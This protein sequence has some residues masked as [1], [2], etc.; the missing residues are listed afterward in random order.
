MGET[1]M[2]VFID[3]NGDGKPDLYVASGGYEFREKDPL[4]QD[5]IYLND[6]KGNFTKS[7]NSLP[8]MLFSKG[9]V[10]AADVNGDGAMDI[11]VGGR[12]IPGKYPVTPQSMLLLNDGHGHF[13]DATAKI[14]PQLD[15]LGMVTDAVWIDVNGDKKPDLIVVGEWMPIKVFVNHNGKLVDESSKYIKF[16]SY[17]LWNKIFAADLNGDGKLDLVVGNV[18]LNTQFKMS[19]QYPMSVCYKDFDKNGTIDPIL[20]YYIDGKNY[21]AVSQDDITGQVPVLKKKFLTYS[22]YADATMEDLFTPDKMKGAKTLIAQ[23]GE[24]VYLQNTGN[25]FV[26]KKLPIEAQYSPVYSITTVD[27]NHDGKP[28]L[29]L[30]GNNAWTRVKFGRYKANHGILLINDGKGNFK[31]IPQFQSGLNLRDDIR[32]AETINSASGQKI[33]FGANDAPLKAYTVN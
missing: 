13:T 30:A 11:F 3:V 2:A 5:H 16:P 26:L 31:Y 25:G 15:T 33:I 24:T 22:A 20:C 8:A 14:C 7:D 4:F 23:T 17:G 1:V 29:V 12:V 27:V 10:R 28:D 21:P 9:C 18:G 32:S 6:G 19:A